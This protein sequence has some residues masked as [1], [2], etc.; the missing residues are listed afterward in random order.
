MITL[1]PLKSYRRLEAVMAV[2]N[3]G[4]TCAQALKAAHV[5]TMKAL[6]RLLKKEISNVQ[7]FGGRGYRNDHLHNLRTNCRQ[8]AKMLHR[9]E[10]TIRNLL[11]RLTSFGWIKKIWHGSNASF[12]VVFNIDLLHI[13]DDE[14]PHPFNVA[15]RFANPLPPLPAPRKNLPHTLPRVPRDTNKQNNS[16]GLSA[17]AD[18]GSSGAATQQQ[19]DTEAGYQPSSETQGKQPSKTGDTKVPAAKKVP[20][21]ALPQEMEDVLALVPAKDRVRLEQYVDQVYDYALGELDQFFPGW[22]AASVR[23]RGRVAMAEY[24]AYTHP[25]LWKEATLEFLDRVE[26]TAKYLER[27]FLDGKN[28]YL[29]LP[30]TYFDHRNASGF[31]GTKRWYLEN[32]QQEK[33]QKIRSVINRAVKDYWRARDSKKIDLTEQLRRIKQYL[34][35]RGGPQLF[36]L[37]KDKL[38]TVTTSSDAAA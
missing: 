5:E 6:I 8:L 7:A 36:Q 21:A 2:Q 22:I 26:L 12:E 24:Y 17:A 32:K 15:D 18:R 27:R 11:N 33:R 4:K 37:F 13:Q 34:E 31:N 25:K 30:N 35:K 3:Q 20:P 1:H 16:K 23:R 19:R 10:R 38:H 14:L 9:S 28:P 29:P